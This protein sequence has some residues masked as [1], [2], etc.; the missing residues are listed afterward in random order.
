MGIR[1]YSSSLYDTNVKN[2]GLELPSFLAFL[3]SFLISIKVYL[4]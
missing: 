4:Y 3:K 1:I 2:H